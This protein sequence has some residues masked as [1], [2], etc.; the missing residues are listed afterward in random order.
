MPLPCGFVLVDFLLLH[1]SLPR[2]HQGHELLRHSP[3]GKKASGGG[4]GGARE[5]RVW[6]DVAAKSGDRDTSLSGDDDDDLGR[7]SGSALP[8]PGGGD[9]GGDYG[10][11]GAENSDS[12]DK[13]IGE[14]RGGAAAAAVPAAEGDTSGEARHPR[15]GDIEREVRQQGGVRDDNGVGGRTKEGTGADREG[16]GEESLAVSQA[17]ALLLQGLISEEELEAVVRKDQVGDRGSS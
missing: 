16:E 15:P 8:S 4:G 3:L 10:G 17:R 1:S 6:G 12:T 14:S 2:S 5:A 13:S 7:E 9:D 11:G